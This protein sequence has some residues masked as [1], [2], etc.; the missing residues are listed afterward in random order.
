M[1][2]RAADSERGL[3]CATRTAAATSAAARVCS[4]IVP[5]DAG[6]GRS[7]GTTWM[8]FI[9]VP[10]LVLIDQPVRGAEQIDVVAIPRPH[11]RLHTRGILAASDAGLCQSHLGPHGG[12]L[13][14]A[15]EVRGFL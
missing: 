2:A 6:A 10:L 15:H 1:A 12:E 14:D 4:T 7:I 13:V 5:C 8:S 3:S 11:A 9:A